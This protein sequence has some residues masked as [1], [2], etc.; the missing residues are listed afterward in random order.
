LVFS[1]RSTRDRHPAG[2]AQD[3][4]SIEKM[5]EEKIARDLQQALDAQQAS[6]GSALASFAQAA[7]SDN[8][9]SLGLGSMTR[10]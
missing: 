4:Y 6:D 9:C 8:R 1:R 3:D 5:I 10:I 2:F 7:Y